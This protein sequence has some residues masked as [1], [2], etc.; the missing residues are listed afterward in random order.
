MT[1]ATRSSENRSRDTVRVLDASPKERRNDSIRHDEYA[2][3]DSENTQRNDIHDSAEIIRIDQHSVDVETGSN[4]GD[5]PR[6]EHIAER[7]DNMKAMT[8]RSTRHSQK[9]Q[10]TAHDGTLQDSVQ[11][12]DTNYLDL[13]S[14]LAEP[15]VVFSPTQVHTQT[16]LFPE[17]QRFART[18]ATVG[19]KRDAT[20]NATDTPVVHRNPFAVAGKT[21]QLPGGLSQLFENTQAASSPFPNVLPLELRSDLPSPGVALQR[22]V[23]QAL[24]SSPMQPI[25]AYKKPGVELVFSFSHSC[26]PLNLAL[27]SLLRLLVSSVVRK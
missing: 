3:H 14:S 11:E 23:Q 8:R 2:A 13:V 19:R 9:T 4:C 10:D 20:G 26:L 18:P 15:A 7:T 21:P 24:S 12:G 5:V 6:E 27:T 16:I 17:S 1:R 22:R 25:S